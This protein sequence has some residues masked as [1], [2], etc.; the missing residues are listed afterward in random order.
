MV[1]S[2]ARR[3]IRDLVEGDAKCS[4]Q[5]A[6]VREYCSDGSLQL[7]TNNYVLSMV[8][9]NLQISTC[10]GSTYLQ[11]IVHSLSIIGTLYIIPTDYASWLHIITVSYTHLTLPTKA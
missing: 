4:K 6:V 8:R 3:A 7:L 5:G 9:E 2:G 10:I 11:I 1:L